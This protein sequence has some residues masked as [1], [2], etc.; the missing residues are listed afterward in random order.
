MRSGREPGVKTK[1][2]RTILEDPEQDTMIWIYIFKTLPLLLLE[3]E[4]RGSRLEVENTISRDV[5]SIT[6]LDYCTTGEN[7][8]I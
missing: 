2:G 6:G 1:F 4:C 5:C 8:E 7:N 3:T